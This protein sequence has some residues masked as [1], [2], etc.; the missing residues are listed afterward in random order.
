MEEDD[1]AVALAAAWGDAGAALQAEI[2]QRLEA[3]REKTEE[4]E[5]Q[6]DCLAK[7]RPQPPTGGGGGKS[8][9]TGTGR[10][11]WVVGGGTGRWEVG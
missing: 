3:L 7:V 5:R 11:D 1:D 10:G 4:A 9:G 2:R 6:P 8:R